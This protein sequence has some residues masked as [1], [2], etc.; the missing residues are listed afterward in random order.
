MMINP[1]YKKWCLDFHKIA[2]HSEQVKVIKQVP[3]F[4]GGLS[5]RQAP[6]LDYNWS[7]GLGRWVLGEVLGERFGCFGGKS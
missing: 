3:V 5:P 1:C 6:L 4:G 2:K 7:R